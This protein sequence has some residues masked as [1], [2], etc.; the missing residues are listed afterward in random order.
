MFAWHCFFRFSN[1][2]QIFILLWSEVR[3]NMKY[4]YVIWKVLWN[5][6]IHEEEGVS[7][8]CKN[9]LHIFH[10][11]AIIW[12]WKLL[13][14]AYHSLPTSIIFLPLLKQN[15]DS[16]MYLRDNL[17]YYF[18]FPSNREIKEYPL[19]TQIMKRPDQKMIKRNK[20]NE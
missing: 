4:E 3:R 16:H 15:S 13:I 11:S 18:W 6:W 17:K 7:L 14:I 20:F 9:L 8:K 19:I 2:I 1:T 10:T 12:M 5:D